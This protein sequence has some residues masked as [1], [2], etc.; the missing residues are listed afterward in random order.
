MRTTTESVRFGLGA[1]LALGCAMAA[2]TAPA[3]AQDAP[4]PDAQPQVAVPPDEQPQVV[5][6]PIDPQPQ[7][8]P[9]VQPPPPQ[10][11]YVQQPPGY[12]QPQQGYVQTQPGYVQTQPGYAPAGPPPR[13]S[14]RASRALIIAGAVALGA[15]W[16][17][18]FVTGLFAG[19]E[20][21]GSSADRWDTFRGVS[22][23][24]I[25]GPW[26]QLAVK[27]TTFEQ[28]DWGTWL[29]IDGL[30]QGAG[31]IMLIAGIATMNDTEPASADAGGGIPFVVLPNVGP[32]HA[33]LSLVGWF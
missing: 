10:Q 11:V 30:L 12:G 19:I 1:A 28:D 3:E 29:I 27:P 22:F 5:I 16:I 14:S 25:A 18:N 15:G 4:P 13:E 20:I 21:F 23:I 7:P 17:A 9:Q 24:P 6:V 33:G 32:G 31:T 8:Q 2:L 26:V